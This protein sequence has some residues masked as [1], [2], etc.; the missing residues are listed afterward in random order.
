MLL[1][2]IALILILGVAIYVHELGH[3]VAAKR[4]GVAVDEFGFGFP[5]RIV[6]IYKNKQGKWK[7]LKGRK[8]PKDK[9]ESTTI[10]SINWIPFGGFVKIK[11]SAGE[12]DDKKMDEN[13]LKEKDSFF[14]QKA[15]KR[16]IIISAGV[17]C[18]IIIAAIILAVGFMIGLPTVVDETT[19]PT[20]MSD[21]QIQVYEVVEG[22]VSE[23][24]G[25][26][27]GDII[28]AM[29]GEEFTQKQ[30]LIDFEADKANQ[31]IILT[32]SRIGEVQDLTFTL[33]ENP[34]TGV[35]VM[36][37]SLV[38]IAKVKYPWYQALWLGLKSTIILTGKIIV[39]IVLLIKGLIVGQSQVAA[40]VAG[41]VGIA[42]LTNQF[43]QMGFVYLLQFA[44]LLSI[45]L[46]IFNFLPLPALDG[47]RIIFI[48]LEKF[49][50][51][52]KVSFKV[53]GLIHTVGFSL[54][55]LLLVFVSIRDVFKFSDSILGF[56]KNLF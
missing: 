49:R 23:G 51:G 35:G 44:A 41:P 20:K 8:E 22:S 40:D 6:G 17:V 2:I 30:A 15:W 10:Y 32:I 26:E 43:T 5:P 14:A 56:F 53:E 37:A 25:L 24:A 9:M 42:I 46:A 54:L 18:N 39:A 13:S 27:L 45:N 3:F 47:G 50:R 12:G 34:D 28:L 19:D 33:D 48:I 21:P 55:L 1:S 4:L 16:A 38:D 52:K 31:E 36:G 11:G 29:N 7:L